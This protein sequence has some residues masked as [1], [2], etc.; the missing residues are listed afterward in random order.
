MSVRVSTYTNVS[1]E[2]MA[3]TRGHGRSERLAEVTGLLQRER[4][5]A[6]V[7]FLGFGDAGRELSESRVAFRRLDLQIRRSSDGVDGIPVIA[8]ETTPTGSGRRRRPAGA[9]RGSF[10]WRS[11]FTTLCHGAIVRGNQGSAAFPNP[12]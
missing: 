1:I 8:S 7:V 9:V 5:L 2:G 11:A 3:R 12:W 10:A 6:H 4:H